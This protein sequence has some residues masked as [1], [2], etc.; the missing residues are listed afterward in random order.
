MVGHGC[1]VEHANGT[2]RL[3]RRALSIYNGV[4]K[5][6]LKPVPSTTALDTIAACGD[7]NH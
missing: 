5:R 4:V 1:H 7:V 2:I 3:V 6:R